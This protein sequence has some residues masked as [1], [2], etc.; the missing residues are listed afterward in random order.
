MYVCLDFAFFVFFCLFV[1]LFVPPQT[2]VW[3][4]LFGGVQLCCVLKAFPLDWGVMYPF[5][6]PGMSRASREASTWSF[7][8]SLFMGDVRHAG[9]VSFGDLRECIQGCDGFEADVADIE[10]KERHPPGRSNCYAIVPSDWMVPLCAGGGT[11]RQ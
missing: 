10:A 11:K 6:A 3:F 2:V 1:S 4:C 7:Q 9:Y 5:K 8:T